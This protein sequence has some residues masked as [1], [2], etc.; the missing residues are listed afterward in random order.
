MDSVD[1]IIDIVHELVFTVSVFKMSS[2]QLKK[3]VLYAQGVYMVLSVLRLYYLLVYRREMTITKSTKLMMA[4]E[5]LNLIFFFYSLKSNLLEIDTLHKIQ[6][7]N[8]TRKDIST[9]SRAK[10]AQK[11][12]KKKEIEKIKE[13]EKEIKKNVKKGKE[14]K[15]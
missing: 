15:K 5:A 6:L 7:N 11:I 1:D 9:H 13:I 2:P 12:I 14:I 8:A 10:N 3:W 4:F